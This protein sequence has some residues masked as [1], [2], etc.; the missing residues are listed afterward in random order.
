MKI[1]IKSDTV[2][3]FPQRASGISLP[4]T[5]HVRQTADPGDKTALVVPTLNAGEGFMNWL[6][7]IRAQSVSP[8]RLIIIDSSSSDETVELA[9]NAGFE[10]YS[11]PREE[12]NHGGTRQ[13]SVD[14]LHDSDLIVFMTQDAIPANSESLANLILVFDDPTIGAAYGRQLPRREANP[15]EAHARLF[16]YPSQSHI[17]GAADIARLG[18]KTSFISNSFAAWRRKA[19]MKTGGFPLYTIQNEDAYAASKL[20]KAGWRIAYCAE[21]MVYHSH[22]Y[23]FIQE[24]QR[25]FD[26]GVFHSCNPWIRHSFG[27]AEGEGLRFVVSELNYLC[28]KRPVLIPSALFRTAL[29]LTGYKLGNIETKLPRWI[30]ARLS[31]NKRYWQ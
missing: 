19:L 16:N 7:A 11:I 5:R 8:E 3:L 10:V 29:K 22:N 31:M 21:A 28:K 6:E 1:G 14:F 9:R 25:Y 27:Q 13:K 2:E 12:F 30:K 15:I 20:I 17:R 24:F 4:E 23:G 26:I 18:L